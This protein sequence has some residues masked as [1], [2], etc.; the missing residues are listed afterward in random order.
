MRFK[1]GLIL[2]D[3]KKRDLEMC[4]KLKHALLQHRIYSKIVPSCCMLEAAFATKP[5]FIIICNPDLLVGEHLALLDQKIKIY[6]IPTEQT[7]FDFREQKNRLVEGH[8][9]TNKEF[10]PPNILAVR[11]YFLWGKFQYK[12]FCSIECLCKNRLQIVGNTRLNPSKK[13]FRDIHKKPTIGILIETAID[14]NFGQ[15]MLALSNMKTIYGSFLDYFSLDINIHFYLLS[16][17][18]KLLE[19]NYNIIIRTKNSSNL[20]SFNW[21]GK[22]IGYDNTC[23]LN[24]FFSKCD[25]VITG[26]SSS[27]LEAYL[28]GVKVISVINLVNQKFLNASM[29]KYLTFQHP[30][31]PSS[32]TEILKIIQNKSFYKSDKAIAKKAKYYLGSTDGMAVFRIAK[33]IAFD[34]NKEVYRKYKNSHKHKIMALRKINIVQ[35]FMYIH[36]SHIIGRFCAWIYLNLK[37]MKLVYS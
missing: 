23:S 34:S 15:E 21:L 19:E 27:G 32:L 10:M 20:K 16:V 29:K 13:S 4:Q 7:I 28:F 6:S 30:N 18:K 12:A 25:Y 8:N 36:R 5:D 37:L 31:S 9:I 26:Q 24:K 1:K 3:Q 35:H 11:K 14:T 22:N 2:F 17:A 33:S